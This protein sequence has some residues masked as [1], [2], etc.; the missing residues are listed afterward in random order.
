M[1]RLPHAPSAAP[2]WPTLGA[3]VAV[4]LGAHLVLLAGGFTLNLPGL[5]HGGPTPAIEAVGAVG[6]TPAAHAGETPAPG[7]SAVRVSSVRWIAP[8]PASQAPA[9]TL[10][11][12]APPAAPAPRAKIQP[13]PPAVLVPTVAVVAPPPV[14]DVAPAHEAV[15]QEPAPPPEVAIEPATESTAADIS[16]TNTDDTLLAAA[17]PGKPRTSAPTPQLPPAQLPAS[18]RLLYD[19][20]GQVKGIGYRAEG[21]LNWT[22]T[23]GRYDARMEMRVPLL[24][25]RSQ[26]SVGRVGPGGLMPERFADK[27][28]SEKAAH[29]ETEKQRIT[30][31]NNAPEAPLQP[32]AQ[33]RLSL[34]LQ[35]AG[36]LQARP[37]AYTTGQTVDMQVAGTGD[38]PLWRFEVGAESTLSLPAGEFKVRR[39]VRLPRKEFDSTV[40]M[41]LAPSLGHLPV[42]LRVT[43]SSGDVADQQLRQM[44]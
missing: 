26:S 42:R 43:Q 1:K 38:A 9:P 22:L 15:P 40:E 20:T 36:L 5:R 7:L 21:T 25:S 12:P 44:P 34:F 28:R 32:G 8:A 11:P 39:L 17:T 35:L 29:F 14:Q 16:A 33:D 18:T 23:D 37:Q 24:G 30:F 13:L 19:V 10:M 4:V 27:S 2:R 3:L 31:S 6:P 41:W